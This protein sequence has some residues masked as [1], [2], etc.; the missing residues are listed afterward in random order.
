MVASADQLASRSGDLIF[1]MGLVSDAYFAGNFQAAGAGL[2]SGFDKLGAYGWDPFA[3]VYRFLLDFNHNGV[4]DFMSVVPRPSIQP[5]PRH[6]AVRCWLESTIVSNQGRTVIRF[7]AN[8]RSVACDT[9]E[10]QNLWEI[11][12]H[13]SLLN[14]QPT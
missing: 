11:S 10:N 6:P 1:Q 3:G 14:E 5:S 4:P 9:T 12:S 7:G 8:C 13:H 2:A